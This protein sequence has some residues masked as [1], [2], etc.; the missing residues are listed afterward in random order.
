[1]ALRNG[2]NDPRNAR[3][4][5]GGTGRA[6]AGS[7]R[8]RVIKP[9]QRGVTLVCEVVQQLNLAK[10]LDMIP[11]TVHPMVVHFPIALLFTGA[12]FDAIGLFAKLDS[13][14]DAG[15]ALETL[16]LISLAV[17]AAAGSIAEHAATLG[18]PAVRSLLRA[19]KRDASLTAVIFGA[20]WL[21][22]VLMAWRRRRVAGVGA[23]YLHLAGVILGLVVLTVTSSLGGS[24]VYDHGVGVATSSAGTR[25]VIA[26]QP[27]VRTA[28]PAER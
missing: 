13:A 27:Y 6:A 11:P 4:L 15:F 23:S 12:L 7:A 26:G 10:L 9:S 5:S 16:G 24:L 3:G 19:H 1:L 25:A 8:E 17:A 20:V 28:P 21:L 22:R 14:A 2:Y 18:D